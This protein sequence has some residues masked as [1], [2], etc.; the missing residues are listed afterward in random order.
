MVRAV[1][2]VVGFGWVLVCLGLAQR[3]PTRRML[4]LAYLGAFLL[5]Q[6]FTAP[7]VSVAGLVP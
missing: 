1:A 7:W 5:V 2:P 3:E 4:P 6:V